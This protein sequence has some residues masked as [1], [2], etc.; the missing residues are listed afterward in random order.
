MPIHDWTRVD[1]G[2]WHAFHVSWISELQ[3]ALNDGILPEGYYA[4]AEQVIGP[5][6]PDVLA[7]Q[8]SGPK[9]APS[10]NGMNGQNG[11]GGSL[12][13]PEPGGIALAT[14]PPQTQIQMKARIPDYTEKQRLI[15]IRHRRGDRV[16]SLIELVSPGNKSSREKWNAFT[17]KALECIYEGYHLL[18]VDL[19]PPSPRDPDGLHVSL[20]SRLGFV[21]EPIPAS[22]PLTLVSYALTPEITAYLEP[23]AVG[24]PLKEMPLFLSEDHYVNVPLENT[25]ELAFRHMPKQFKALLQQP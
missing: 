15:A 13:Q 5:Y 25:Y 16:I 3:G 14:S 24:K 11:A 2:T 18:L 19:F 12:H 6:G 7:M 23:T 22:D 20:W 17:G 9:E 21:S 8:S 1:A 4:Q 10:P